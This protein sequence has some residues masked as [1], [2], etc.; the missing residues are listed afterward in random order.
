MKYLNPLAWVADALKVYPEPAG[1]PEDLDEAEL[2]DLARARNRLREISAVASDLKKLV[3]RKLVGKLAGA[4]YRYGNSI[5]RGGYGRTVTKVAD[6]AEWW[7]TV[8]R[9]L[10]QTPNP[11]RLLDALYPANEVKI[12]GLPFLAAA[13]GEDPNELRKQHLRNEKADQPLTETP[14]EKAPKY[15]RRLR[16]GQTSYPEVRY[17]SVEQALEESLEALREGVE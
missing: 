3:E 15:L 13:L 8:V 4:G 11:D 17:D 7:R 6:P 1:F 12:S 5:L 10:K 2:E 9:A 16:E 14:I